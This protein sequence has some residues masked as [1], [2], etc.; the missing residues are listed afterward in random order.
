MNNITTWI[1]ALRSGRYQQG[2]ETLR[3]SK[4]SFCCLGVACDLFNPLG[5]DYKPDEGYVFLDG[6]LCEMPPVVARH[7]G[8]QPY[9]VDPII[10]REVIL[11]YTESLNDS[12]RSMVLRSCIEDYIDGTNLS[13]LNDTGA[14]FQEIADLIERQFC[15]K[16]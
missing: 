16:S 7:F 4:D 12:Y 10:S 5:W 8:L 11:D 1:E 13:T 2:D 6:F 14:T 3:A 15:P 9:E